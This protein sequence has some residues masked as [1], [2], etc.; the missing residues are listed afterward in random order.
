M[1]VDQS[2]PSRAV[3]LI[4]ALVQTPDFTAVK[5]MEEFW[6]GPNMDVKC[7]PPDKKKQVVRSGLT[8]FRLMSRY[9]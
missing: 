1:T 9:L 5:G 4:L 2:Y 3:R 8:T 6:I 7:S